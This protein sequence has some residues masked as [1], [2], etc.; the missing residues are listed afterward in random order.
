[1]QVGTTVT[2][3]LTDPDGN[4]RNVT[5][6]WERSLSRTSGWSNIPG[7]TSSTYTTAVAGD[8]DSFLR[9]TARYDDGDGVDKDAEAVTSTA[10]AEDDDGVVTLS[11]TTPSIGETV[12]ATLTDPDGG[13]TG[14]VWQW[15]SSP[16]GTTNW[17]NIANATSST[18]TVVAANLNNYLRASVSYHD[19][20]GAG[21]S[22]EAITTASV[23]AD[24]DGTVTLTPSSPQVSDRVTAV[25]SDPDGGVTGVTWQWDISSNGT[26]GWTPIVGANAS[27]LTVTSSY[28]NNYLRAT[29]SYSDAA[30]SGKSAQAVSAA[31]VSVDDDGTV[32]LSTR[33]PEVGSAV[34]ASLSDPDTPLRNVSWQWAKSSN[35]TTGWTNIDGATSANYTPG[36]SDAGSFLRATVSYDDS[37]GYWEECAGGNELEVWR[38]QRCRSGTMRTVTGA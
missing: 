31:A 17:T 33:T 20:V 32:T 34:R 1:M 16:D 11:S 5:W 37:V 30:G 29:A 6:Q 28:L 3:R 7:A 22:A 15:A 35:G 25:L 18:Y 19:A 10:V 4:I 9:A 14:A 21:K 27:T 23:T 24:N 38:K 26:S 8:V 12:T 13:V 2:A 36:R